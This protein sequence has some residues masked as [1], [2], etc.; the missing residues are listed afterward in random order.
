MLGWVLGEATLG[1][2]SAC[3][4]REP[5]PVFMT[6]AQDS[7]CCLQAAPDGVPGRGAASLP[8]PGKGP[9]R[10]RPFHGVHAAKNMWMLFHRDENQRQ[11]SAT[12]ASEH[13][14]GTDGRAG[15]WGGSHPLSNPAG[16]V[17]PPL[18]SHRSSASSLQGPTS[19][20]ACSQGAL[21]GKTKGQL[22][23]SGLMP[24]GEARDPSER[25]Q[26][27]GRRCL[28]LKTRA[29]ESHPSSFGR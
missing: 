23:P 5:T 6:P 20:P 10:S 14:Q 28:D 7:S 27:P 9:H 13:I 12:P 8:V 24:Q 15:R 3:N 16:Q 21:G 17:E 29:Q 25:R 2:V 26:G 19:A 1:L 4:V 22:G 18:N 11:P